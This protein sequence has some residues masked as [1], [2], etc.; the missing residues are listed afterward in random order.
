MVG[1]IDGNSSYPPGSG[2][3]NT[4]KRAFDENVDCINEDNKRVKLSTDVEPVTLSDTYASELKETEEMFPEK[5]PDYNCDS[6]LQVD[7]ELFL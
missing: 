3:I 5:D 1:Q 4:R 7:L 6:S 2:V